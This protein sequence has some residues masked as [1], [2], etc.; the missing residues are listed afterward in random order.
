[1]VVV[2]FA[3]GSHAVK[4]SLASSIYWQQF[5]AQMEQQ[6]ELRWEILG[7][8]DCEG[9]KSANSD[10]RRQRAEAIF[11][12]LP[13]GA[14]RS[15]T[16]HVGASTD[17]CMTGNDTE[18]DRTMNRSV[19]IRRAEVGTV[20][21]FDESDADVI[22]AER[23]KFVCGPDVTSE[24][25]SALGNVRGTF[26]GWSTSQREDACD[27]L[28]SYPEGEYAWDIVELH[29]NKWIYED[30]RPLCATAGATPPC[31]STVQVADQCYTAGAPNYVVFGTMCKLCFDHYR[32]KSDLSG[33]YRFSLSS[34]RSLINLYKGKGVTGLGTPSG[35][36][37]QS[38]SWAEA[39]YAGWAG[40][41]PTPGDRMNCKPL[42][43]TKYS[44]PA[45]RVHWYP[46][47]VLETVGR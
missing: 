14:Q 1:M 33:A 26:L 7:L 42:C 37:P 34:M 47:L 12:T 8:S 17:E 6:S 27:A 20:I 9:S 38:L 30:Y 19:L 44:G 5:V 45:F 31:G 22:E 39:G 29:N 10:L 15:V 23:A 16:R 18:A 24:I 35:N 11:R 41:T 25:A 43:P 32:A 4:A 13:P 46:N 36:F 3:V 40:G 2:N 21:E 28:D